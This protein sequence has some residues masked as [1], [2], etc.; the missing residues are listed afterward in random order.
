MAYSVC[1]WLLGHY[2]YSLYVCK[3]T[4]LFPLSQSILYLFMIGKM[5]WLGLVWL[6]HS[7]AM[8]PYYYTRVSSHQAP[9]LSYADRGIRAS[10]ESG[11]A[12]CVI[13]LWG[14]IWWLTPWGL[15]LW[16]PAIHRWRRPIQ[17]DGRTD[18]AFT[19]HRRHHPSFVKVVHRHPGSTLTVNSVATFSD[20]D[21]CHWRVVLSVVSSI[22][23][24]ALRRMTRNPVS[25]R[26]SNPGGW[27]IR[28]NWDPRT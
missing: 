15:D 19:I 13:E 28:K 20:W 3:R 11:Y 4:T 22:R 16:H 23:E 27:G 18:A 10:Q 2:Y 17:G 8:V 14:R 7:F 26:W 21:P 12:H 24:P 6:Q 25:H 1:V 9:G 5:T